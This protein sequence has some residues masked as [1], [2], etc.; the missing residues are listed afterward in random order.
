MLKPSLRTL[1]TVFLIVNFGADV[2]ASDHGGTR[3]S[4]KAF[5]SRSPVL[6]RNGM[7]ATSHPLA[8]AVAVDILKR[9]G[10]AVD[11]AIAA[12]AMLSL[13]E[14]FACG[15]GGDLFAIVFS[16]D[17]KSLHGL[18]ASGRSPQG[19]STQKLR[20]LTASTGKIPLR[21]PLTV[22]V[23]GAVDGWFRLHERFGILPMKELLA[24]AIRYAREGVPITEVDALQWEWGIEGLEEPSAPEGRFSNFKQTFLSAGQ[25]PEVG[26]IFRNPDLAATYESIATKGRNAFY[27]GE[28]AISIA[29]AVQAAGGF[30]SVEDLA[31]HQGNWVKPVSVN[32]RGYEVYELPPPTQGIAAL[33]MLKILEHFDLAGMGRDSA[34]FWHVLIEAKKL[35]YEDRARY[36]ADPAFQKTPVEALLSDAYARERSKRIQMKTAAPAVEAGSPP[37]KGDTTYIATADAAGMMVSLIQSN[38]WEFGSWVV[39]KGAGFVLQNRGSSFSLEDGHANVYAPGKRPFH[40]IIPAFVM[41]DGQPVMSFGV[42]GGALQPQ[43]HVQILI[44][45]IDF[46]MNVQEAGDAARLIHSGSSQPNG[47][48]ADGSGT[49]ELEA[50]IPRAVADELERRG[51]RVSNETR[52]YVGGYQAIWRD[53][54][55]GVYHG[56][57]EMRFDGQAV[58][59]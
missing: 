29:T 54:K 58:G 46:G 19:L 51:H 14:P 21:G 49:V 3:L 56:A 1:L 41:R 15:I 38:F 17:T 34:D 52:P 35:A 48:A 20:E 28:L 55:T 37:E 59:Y 9:G 27:T 22:S 25:P 12:N 8:S 2:Q 39:P 50:G 43:A 42:M 31:A 32:Y 30:L 36:Y 13:V 18:N 16:P 40:T 23:P 5:A 6:A 47:K 57:S 33:Q 7:A 24:P 45:Q 26:E 11:A 44:N 4:G 53:P 10:S